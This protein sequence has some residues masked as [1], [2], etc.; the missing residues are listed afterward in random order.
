MLGRMKIPIYALAAS[1]L[2]GGFCSADDKVE[3]PSKLTLNPFKKR[4]DKAKAKAKA[5]CM[6]LKNAIST[7]Y[8]EYGKL[9]FDKG[10]DKELKLETKGF[11]IRILAGHN[12]DGLNPKELVFIET[13]PA[14]DGRGGSVDLDDK[15]KARLLDPWGRPYQVILDADYGG[16]I[17]V[18]GGEVRGT[19][20]VYSLGPDGKISDDDI[21]SWE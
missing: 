20:G 18:P 16:E 17:K 12:D 1:L 9:P 14:K 13:R 8:L 11:P 10:A 5:G 4:A 2:L 15:D 7:Y 21:R 6:N 3:A 19:A